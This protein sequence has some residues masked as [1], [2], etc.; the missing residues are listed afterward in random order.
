MTNNI[1]TEEILKD[2]QDTQEEID[3]LNEERS[4]LEKNPKENKVRL[5]FIQGNISQRVG[6][7]NKLKEILKL[8]GR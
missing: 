7:I 5:Y 1:P 2:I 3:N 8:R 6:F 4:V